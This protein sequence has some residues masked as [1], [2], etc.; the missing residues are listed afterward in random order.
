MPCVEAGALK[1]KARTPCACRG[2]AGPHTLPGSGP[3]RHEDHGLFRIS[4]TIIVSHNVNRFGRVT[5]LVGGPKKA[6]RAE[7]RPVHS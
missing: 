6:L 3:V 7:T 5:G 4:I 2:Q 1:S